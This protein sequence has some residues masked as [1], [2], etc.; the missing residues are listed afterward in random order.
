MT[1]LVALILIAL[2]LGGVAITPLVITGAVCGLIAIT[3]CMFA[4]SITIVGIIGDSLYLGKMRRGEAPYRLPW[5]YRWFDWKQGPNP[6][7]LRYQSG[8]FYDTRVCRIIC[9]VR[10]RDVRC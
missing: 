4:L 6:D 2:V 8:M 7:V 10:P 9:V 3:A 1:L 5:Y